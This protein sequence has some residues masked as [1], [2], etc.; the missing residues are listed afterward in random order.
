MARCPGCGISN[1]W[2]QCPHCG[3]VRCGS[4]GRNSS[5]TKA[6]AANKCPTCGKH[7]ASIHVGPPSWAK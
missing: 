1:N 5:G 4:C 2:I 6:S 7:H 3:S